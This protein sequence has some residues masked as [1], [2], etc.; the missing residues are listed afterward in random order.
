MGELKATT[1]QEEMILAYIN[2]NASDALKAKIKAGTKTMEQCMGFIKSEAKKEA[3]NGVA[4][5]EDR[6][7]FGWAVHFFEEDDI[8]PQEKPTFPISEKSQRHEKLT[9]RNQVPKPP[10][11]EIVPQK[12]PQEEPQLDGQMNIFDFL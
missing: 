10:K 5:I 9:E 7:V 3:K 6:V 12:K 4:M 2:N 11:R 1:Q 8:K